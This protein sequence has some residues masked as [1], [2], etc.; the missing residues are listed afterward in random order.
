[1]DARTIHD[2]GV[3]GLTAARQQLIERW[4]VIVKPGL[5]V[6]WTAMKR[7]PRTI[8]VSSERSRVIEEKLQ[9]NFRT[10]RNRNE[11]RGY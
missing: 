9:K 11:P 10:L 8:K 7:L 5:T 3:P 4:R 1:M 6:I 2:V